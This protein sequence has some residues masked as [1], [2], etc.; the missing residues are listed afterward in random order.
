MF[1]YQTNPKPSFPQLI[2]VTNFSFI[3]SLVLYI[4]RSS[5]FMLRINLK[6]GRD[7]PCMRG[8]QKVCVERLV[9]L[10]LLGSRNSH[11][12]LKSV[13]RH[14]ACPGYILQEVGFH[15]TI[16][17]RQDLPEPENMLVIFFEIMVHCMDPEIGHQ[18]LGEAAKFYDLSLAILKS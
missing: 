4:G 16:E 9:N 2:A 8:R 15:F 1:P 12:R 11:E 17:F 10:E 18:K 14:F 13:Y 6:I 3:S 5:W 7:S